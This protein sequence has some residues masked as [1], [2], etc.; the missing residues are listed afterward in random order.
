MRLRIIHLFPD[1]STL[2][3]SRY[4]FIIISL[5]KFKEDNPWIRMVRRDLPPGKGPSPGFPSPGIVLPRPRLNSSPF[6]VSRSSRGWHSSPSP[7]LPT[8]HGSSSR[9][10]RRW[11]VHQVKSGSPWVAKRSRSP[12]SFRWGRCSLVFH[13]VAKYFPFHSLYC[14]K[15]I[16]CHSPRRIAPTNMKG[17]LRKNFKNS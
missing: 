6:F 4:V 5:P 7:D 13:F 12:L 14:N 17:N 8:Y 2:I 1:A 15:K 9:L 11:C 10:D 3:I 16:H